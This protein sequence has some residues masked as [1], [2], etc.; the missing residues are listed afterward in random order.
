MNIHR[1]HKRC[2]VWDVDWWKH[3]V[4]IYL[5]IYICI[6]IN[7]FDNVYNINILNQSSILV[8]FIHC[9]KLEMRVWMEG[10]VWSQAVM[11]TLVSPRRNQRC[12]SFAIKGPPES[13]WQTLEPFLMPSEHSWVFKMEMCPNYV[14]WCLRNVVCQDISQ[15]RFYNSSSKYN[16]FQIT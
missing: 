4:Q 3:V 16:Q 9:Q 1:G 8:S 12:S 14:I 7:I 11:P 2:E 10:M 13:P 15:L 5:L 6:H